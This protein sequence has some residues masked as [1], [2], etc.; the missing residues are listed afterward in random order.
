MVWER[1][2][3]QLAPGQLSSDSGCCGREPAVCSPRARAHT[4]RTPP[5]GPRFRSPTPT[6]TPGSRFLNQQGLV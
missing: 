5:P 1:V 6:P 2:F 4:I 3:R